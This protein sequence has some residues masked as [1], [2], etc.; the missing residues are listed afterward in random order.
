MKLIRIR[1]GCSLFLTSEKGEEKL[2]FT[3]M[4]DKRLQNNAQYKQLTA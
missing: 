2:K 4:W 1:E 3:H